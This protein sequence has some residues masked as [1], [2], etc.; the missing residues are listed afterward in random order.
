MYAVNVRDVNA[1]LTRRCERGLLSCTLSS[2]QLQALSSVC[3][4]CSFGGLGCCSCRV[5]L[6]AR[7]I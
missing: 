5:Y 3:G 1:R 7:D 6:C 4:G 2:R